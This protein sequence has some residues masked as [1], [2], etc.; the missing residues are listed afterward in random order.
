MLFS[1]LF[2]LTTSSLA[3]YRMRSFLTGLGIAI[4]MPLRGAGSTAGFSMSARMSAGTMRW[5]N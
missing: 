2:R 1:D 3:A 5:I 4:G